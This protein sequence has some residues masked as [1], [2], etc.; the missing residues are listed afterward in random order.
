MMDKERDEMMRLREENCTLLRRENQRLR[1]DLERMRKEKLE[2]MCRWEEACSEINEVMDLLREKLRQLVSSVPESGANSEKSPPKQLA[3][4]PNVLN[5]RKSRTPTKA[6]PVKKTRRSSGD[7]LTRKLRQTSLKKV[8]KPCDW[9]K[10]GKQVARTHLA[11]TS[12]VTVKGNEGRN[13][14]AA[15]DTKKNRLRLMQVS[16]ETERSFGDGDANEGEEGRKGCQIG[17]RSREGGSR[18]SEDED[19]ILMDNH[20]ELGSKW[21]DYMTLL[22]GRTSKAIKIRWRRLRLMRSNE[23][24]VDTKKNRLRLVQVSPVLP[25]GLDAFLD[26]LLLLLKQ[27]L[28][29]FHFTLFGLWLR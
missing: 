14:E 23:A 2:T 15:V 28:T 10:L 5:R 9:G 27:W 24:A 12:R 4:P 18:W 6:D 26:F 20:K 11:T 1:E 7:T 8:S 19:K 3:Y 29:T 13:N 17:G 22:P 21:S 25:F 16:E